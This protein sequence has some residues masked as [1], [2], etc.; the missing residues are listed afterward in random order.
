MRNE[1]SRRHAMTWHII[2]Q[3]R[4]FWQPFPPGIYHIVGK[5]NHFTRSISKN[6]F[7]KWPY[8]NVIGISYWTTNLL[9]QTVAICQAM[10]WRLVFLSLKINPSR[11]TLDHQQAFWFH[12]WVEGIRWLQNL[13]LNIFIEIRVN[14]NLFLMSSL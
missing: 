4:Q 5:E 3:F 7:K 13:I 1:K 11:V 14:T 10:V 9:F 2:F 12:L 8:D 6:Y